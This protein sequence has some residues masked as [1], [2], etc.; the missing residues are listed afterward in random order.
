M[1]E[2]GECGVDLDPA[3][4]FCIHCGTPV[5]VTPVAGTPLPVT[6]VAGT[7]LPVTPVAGTPAPDTEPV[8]R[9]RPDLTSNPS[10]SPSPSSSLSANPSPSPA[11]APVPAARMAIP[12]AIRP[13]LHDESHGDDE[14]GSDRPAFDIP[15][16]LGI[17][18]GVF[19]VIA[20][21]TAFI[22][23]IGRG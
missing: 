17:A 12:S 20:M 11:S 22:I 6:P 10:P 3:W 9:P 7:P 16:V 19:G 1:E 5:A 18:I 13:H 15:L 8:P 4:K 2:C 21:A 14:V 23:L